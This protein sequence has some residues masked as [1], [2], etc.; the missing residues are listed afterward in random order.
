M[1]MC[2]PRAAAA[3]GYIEVGGAR[4]RY[5]D[6]GRGLPVILIHGWALD[7]DMWQPQIAAWA[8][9]LRVIRFD[10]RG[11]GVS[12]GQPSLAADARDVDSLLRRLNLARVAI[13]G[14][15]QGARVAMRVAAGPMRKRVVCLILDGAPFD[16]SD[17]GEP[18][19]HLERYREL[20]QRDGISAFRKEWSSHPFMQLRSNDRAANELLSRMTARYP[21]NDLL[22]GPHASDG[23]PNVVDAIDAAALVLNGALDTTRRR[24]MGD[25]L[26]RALP[27][28]ERA[29]VPDSGHLPNL[30]NPADYNRL[31]L[32]FI[33]RRVTGW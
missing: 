24:S 33:E 17:V 9:H 31:V 20:A 3:D 21:A 22:A 12:T 2:E 19:V 10:R 18:E 30:D 23:E 28:A 1:V 8:P 27:N 13:L 29:L 4:L 11:F 7:L 6:E 5:R 16:G 14:M 15:S 26:C 25:E 32:A